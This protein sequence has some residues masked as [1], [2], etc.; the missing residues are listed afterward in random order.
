MNV[1]FP[2][3]RRKALAWMG[4]IG[5]GVLG[6]AAHAQAALDMAT[7]VVGLSPG[8]A[9]D[10]AARKLADGLRGSYAR[11]AIVDNRTGAGARLAVQFVKAAAPTGT[12]MLLTP[13]SMMAIYPHT[14]KDLAY[15]PL[16]DLVPVGMVATS[17]LGYAVGPAVPETVKTLGDYLTWLRGSAANATFGHGA[18]GSGPHFLGEMLGRLSN[19]QMT[20]A[21]YRGSQPALLEMLGGHV[22]AVAAPLGEFLPHLKSGK[23]RVLGVTGSRRSRFMP[24]VP[25]FKEIGIALSEMTEW[26]G[27]FAPAGTPDKIVQQANVAMKA[28]LANPDL[29]IAYGNMGME[30]AWSTAGELSDRLRVDTERWRGVVRQI[31]FTAQS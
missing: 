30:T 19:V 2:F 6:H 29:V 31:G 10:A 3:R 24:E 23:V 20:Q 11:T 25:T 5:A 13:A 9:T 28:A 4:A 15:D 17:E 8:G 22:P 18:T 21:G 1:N 14:Y 27:V 26:F 12:T 16:K 7:I